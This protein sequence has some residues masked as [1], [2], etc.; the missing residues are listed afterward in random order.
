[1]PTFDPQDLI[2]A[3]AI[4]ENYR[5]PA[6]YLASGQ[7]ISVPVTVVSGA[8]TGPVLL[9]TGATHGTEVTGTRALLRLIKSLDPT[10]MRGT[11]VAVPVA[12]PL[13]FDRS[14]YG[15]PEDG[16]HLAEECY[17]PAV[18]DGTAT[19]RI[20]SV[21]RPLL[22]VATHYIDL[23]NNAEPALPMAMLFTESCLTVD[24]RRVQEEMAQAF[25]L[26]SVRM[27]EPNDATA[28]RV[29]S[30][31]GQPA[32][33]ASAHGVPGLMV[34]LLDQD[35]YRG[36]EV[37]II[38]VRNVMSYLGMIASPPETQPVPVISEPSTYS[39]ILRAQKPG[40]LFPLNP[41]GTVLQAG[42]PVAE[43]LNMHGDVAEVVLMPVDGFVWAFLGASQGIGTMAIPEGHTV[44]FFASLDR[45]QR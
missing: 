24:V 18:P 1:M 37:G 38:G 23:H 42:E 9:V 25:G 16:M 20:G 43:I 5:L 19:Q 28:R 26:T 31:D 27:I 44:G 11:L 12:N 34:E 32:A 6:T 35:G 29:G 2:T 45:P 14:L 36:E 30:I 3:R 39:G 7:E 33:A 40:V 8:E 15:S 13:A 41:P 22:D 4:V 10:A 17:W 21:I